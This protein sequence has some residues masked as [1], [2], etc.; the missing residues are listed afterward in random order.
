MSKRG[1]NTCAMINIALCI[2]TAGTCPKSNEFRDPRLLATVYYSD[3]RY[4]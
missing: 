1:W 4:A 3:E 2:L